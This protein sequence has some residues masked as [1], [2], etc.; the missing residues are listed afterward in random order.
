MPEM[1]ML[2]VVPA[3]GGS[4]GIP[5]KNTVLLA[6]RPLLEYTA[7]AALGCRSL[8]RTVLSTE[9]S[10]IADVGRRCGLEVA[11]MRP[12]ELAQDDT[13]MLSVLQHA[14]QAL[15]KLDGDRPD[16]VVLLQPTSPLRRS[17]HIDAACEIFRQSDC[18]SVVSVVEVPHRFAPPSLMRLEAGRLNPMEGGPLPIRRQDKPRLYARNGPA[19]LVVRRQEI[20]EHER[21]WGPD[22]RAYV[23]DSTDSVDIDDPSDLEWA[24]ALLARRRNLSETTP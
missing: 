16:A 13:P 14:I 19:I 6:G 4:K 8:A 12:A 9:D 7:R 5:H 18:D 15:E 1:R 2:G 17:E 11:F 20:L 24:E 10:R 23:M 3:R 21:L 22:C